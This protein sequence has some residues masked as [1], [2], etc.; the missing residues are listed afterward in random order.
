MNIPWIEVSIHYTQSISKAGVVPN[1]ETN[2]TWLEMPNTLAS[3]FMEFC[4]YL[5][6]KH[7]CFVSTSHGCSTKDV[8][9]HNSWRI[10]GCNSCWNDPHCIQGTNIPW[11]AVATSVPTAV[12]N[13]LGL[14]TSWMTCTTWA[15]GLRI[16]SN[17][18]SIRRSNA[19][20]SKPQ[21]WHY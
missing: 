6:S 2:A 16:R 4:I 12:W 21:V 7:R 8:V 10:S 13:E 1:K 11:P 5:H 18:A 15:V 3:D 20:A 9:P 17:R 19:W 14:Q